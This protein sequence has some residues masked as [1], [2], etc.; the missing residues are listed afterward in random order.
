MSQVKEVL[1]PQ[2]ASMVG[3][4]LQPT[5]LKVRDDITTA[6]DLADAEVRIGVPNGDPPTLFN[7]FMDVYA[8]SVMGSTED[9]RTRT[10]A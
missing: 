2:L 3:Y 7:I 9:Y 8:K 6:S 4:L 10:A 5:L 1:P